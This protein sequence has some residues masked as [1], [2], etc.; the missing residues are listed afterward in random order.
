MNRTGTRISTDPPAAPLP[1]RT[2]HVR[3]MS[4]L[5]DD[6]IPIPG[7]RRRI[8]LD[9][10]LG[11]VPGLGDLIGGVM[12][13][14]I[15]LEATRARVPTTMLV[16]MLVNVGIDTM[17]GI[18]PAI[19]DLFDAAW[20]SNMRNVTLLERH[21]SETE[22]LEVAVAAS[23]EKM[24]AVGRSIVALA[25]LVAIVLGGVALG[26]FAGRMLWRQFSQ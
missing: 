7:T 5:M 9:A 17:I 13:G 10:I 25:V 24:E 22:A 26:I 8:G 21:L 6:S 16:K 2:K 3:A 1:A 12:S 18:V 4:R 11:L 15:I 20:K 19:G 14:W 23:G